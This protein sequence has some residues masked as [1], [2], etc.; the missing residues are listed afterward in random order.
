MAPSGGRT[1]TNML[2]KNQKPTICHN[3][4]KIG[5]KST[6]CQEDKIDRAQLVQILEASSAGVNER[7]NC[8]SC[9][10]NGHYANICPYKK[11]PLDQ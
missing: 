5:H 3:C 11:K 9:G 8:F 2:M 6:Y 7:V 4:G 1:S 10:Q